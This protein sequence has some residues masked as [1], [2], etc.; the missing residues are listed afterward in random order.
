MNN[1]Y[2]L[3]DFIED[4]GDEKVASLMG[5]ANVAQAV[6]GKALKS[7]NPLMTVKSVGDTAKQ[8]AV[9]N[10]AKQGHAD[11]IMGVSG[12]F[13]KVAALIKKRKEED[14]KYSSLYK[15][16]KK[17][18]TSRE[19]ALVAG[20]ATVAGLSLYGA[21]K[22]K[23]PLWAARAI[24]RN[25]AA[26]ASKAASKLINNSPFK[27]VA[28][29]ASKAVNDTY[30][31]HSPAKDAKIGDKVDSMV[32]G[33]NPANLASVFGLSMAMMAGKN[34]GDLAYN[35]FMEH[36]KAKKL[37]NQEEE[38]RQADAISSKLKAE[39][40]FKKASIATGDDIV[41]AV[42]KSVEKFLP[43]EIKKRE[44]RRNRYNSTVDYVDH[45]AH[46]GDAPQR[47]NK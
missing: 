40:L 6:G 23:D 29:E 25:K 47:R 27:D 46:G 38:Q 17:R 1:Q 7:I 43:E 39:D 36:V 15:R 31:V 33:G 4:M 20:G 28:R 2:T 34:T 22:H 8:T 14:N 37:Q 21:A 44:D 5:A 32:R 42:N 11:A 30:A 24:N 19:R 10:A 41:T 45:G 3:Y 16:R 18:L 13:N 35:R 9:K 26:V 12:R